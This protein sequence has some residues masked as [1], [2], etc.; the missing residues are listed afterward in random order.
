MRQSDI[1]D[2][3]YK[4]VRKMGKA[5]TDDVFSYIMD[6]HRGAE[7]KPKMMPNRRRVG[8]IMK[9]DSRFKNIGKEKAIWV[10]K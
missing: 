2:I 8:C 5:T 6:E 4:I 1:A 10:L 3:C 9:A 7:G